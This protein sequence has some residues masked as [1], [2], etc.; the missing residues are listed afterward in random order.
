M[1]FVQLHRE[2]I[3]I[4]LPI[5]WSVCAHPHCL[6]AIRAVVSFA[7]IIL[8]DVILAPSFLLLQIVLSSSTGILVELF[9]VF[10]CSSSIFLI[11]FY[12]FFLFSP[13]L[14]CLPHCPGTTWQN[15]QLPLAL[16]LRSVDLVSRTVFSFPLPSLSKVFWLMLREVPF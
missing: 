8:D 3:T 9:I 7:A 10:M 14:W 16:G 13:P 11:C 1:H 12:S 4:P 6:R 15:R 5:C 2:L